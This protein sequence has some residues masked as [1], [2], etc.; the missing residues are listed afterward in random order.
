MPENLKRRQAAI[1]AGCQRMPL[2]TA[3]MLEMPGSPIKIASKPLAGN[4]DN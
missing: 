2:K 4:L 1:D 3:T